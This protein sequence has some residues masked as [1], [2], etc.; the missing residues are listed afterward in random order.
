MTMIKP[1]PQITG[2]S[3]LFI[4]RLN[5]EDVL[6]VRVRCACVCVYICAWA[7]VPLSPHSNWSWQSSPLRWLKRLIPVR[8]ASER[9]GEKML[10]LQYHQFLST[11]IKVP[12]ITG[13]LLYFLTHWAPTDWE[14]TLLSSSFLSPPLVAYTSLFS[15]LIYSSSLFFTS[16]FL[17]L[18]PHPKSHLCTKLRAKALHSHYSNN[19][20][21]WDLD[22]GWGSLL[23][24]WG[25]RSGLK[26]FVIVAKWCQKHFAAGTGSILAAKNQQKSF[27]ICW[28]LFVVRDVMIYHCI[29]NLNAISKSDIAFM[30]NAI[31]DIAFMESQKLFALILSVK[32][33]KNRN[34]PITQ[35]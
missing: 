22:W 6:R 4:F 32:K 19:N 8:G 14:N 5:R 9:V 21:C 17:V 20:D 16:M 28:Y 35:Q 34:W 2:V 1:E 25:M 18:E 30:E 24:V 15:P 3:H 29:M 13:Y 12:D 27:W 11:F 7:G 33:K 10:S 31:S 26:L 23:Q